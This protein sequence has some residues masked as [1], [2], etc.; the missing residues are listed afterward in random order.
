LV[1]GT[2]LNVMK[3][4]VVVVVF[5]T[6]NIPPQQKLFWVVGWVVAILDAFKNYL[7][8]LSHTTNKEQRFP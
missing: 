5:F 3:P 1:S 7:I 4:V 6:D 8:Y 2:A